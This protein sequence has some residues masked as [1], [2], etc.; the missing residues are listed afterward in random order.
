[1]ST[2]R[3]GGRNEADVLEPHLVGWTVEAVEGGW[4]GGDGS[5]V[6]RLVRGVERKTI[7]V[8]VNDH[9]LWMNCPCDHGHGWANGVR[10][11]ACRGVVDH[12]YLLRPEE[13]G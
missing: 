5:L 7:E 9:G 13:P 3:P 12:P 1:M 2:P 8:G 11:W 10:G 4:Y 6:F